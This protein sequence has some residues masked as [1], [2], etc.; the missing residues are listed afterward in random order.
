MRLFLFA[1]IA[2]NPKPHLAALQ[3][4]TEGEEVYAIGPKYSPHAPDRFGPS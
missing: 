1:G 3:V 2:A 4:L